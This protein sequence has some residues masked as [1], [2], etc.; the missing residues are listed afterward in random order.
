MARVGASAAVVHAYETGVDW[1][2]LARVDHALALGVRFHPHYAHQEAVI[3]AGQVPVNGVA[4]DGYALR[5][6]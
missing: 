5:A 6:Q 1:V 4:C 3:E 2:G